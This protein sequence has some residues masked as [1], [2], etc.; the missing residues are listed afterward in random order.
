MTDLIDLVDN[1]KIYVYPIHSDDWIDISQWPE[2]HKAQSHYGKKNFLCIITA[3]A[4]SKIIKIK[5][6]KNK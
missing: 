1:K 3:R 5:I 4:N 6:Y 2:Y